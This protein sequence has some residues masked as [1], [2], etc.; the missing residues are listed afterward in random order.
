MFPLITVEILHKFIFCY[1]F[2]SFAKIKIVGIF[3]FQL[4]NNF[5]TLQKI[6]RYISY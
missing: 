1:I 5:I 4:A 3:D 2:I 6:I